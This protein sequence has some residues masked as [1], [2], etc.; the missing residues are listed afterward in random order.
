MKLSKLSEMRV[1]VVD[2]L[3]YGNRGKRLSTIDV[4]SVGP[5]LIAGI[6]EDLNIQYEFYL[7]KEA[8]KEI[9]NFRSYDVLLASG[10]ATDLGSMIRLAKSFK[11]GTKIAGGPSCVEYKKLLMSGYDFV[12]FGES[13][14]KLPL[15]IKDLITYGDVINNVEGLLRLKNGEVY[16]TLPTKYVVPEVLWKYK[17]SS[18]VIKKYDWWWGARTYIEVVRG[19]SNFYRPTLNLIRYPVCKNCGLCRE[20][21]LE[22]RIHCPLGIPPGCGY[23]SV[24]Q[25]YGPAR[26]KPIDKVIDEV[27]DL[28]RVGVRRIV[29][30]APDFLDYGRDWL[31]KPKPL[32]DPRNPKPNLKVIEE[33][34]TKLFDI[35]EIMSGDSYIMIENIKPNL[36]DEE[37]AKLLGNYLKGST[38]GIGL[39]TGDNVLHKALGRPSTVGEVVKAVKLLCRYGLKPH[40]YLIHGLPYEDRK[41]IKNTVN[42]VRKLSRLSIEKFTL[43]RFTPL[44]GT[45]FEGFQ[46]PP[47]AVESSQARELYEVVK[48]YNVALKKRAIGSIVKAVIASRKG[49]YLVAYPLPHGP[50]T[51]LKG[52]SCYIGNVVWVKLTKVASDRE[53]FG[54]VVKV[55]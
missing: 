12:V 45:A 37:V 10:M 31:I 38:L 19:C 18:S 29:L 32:T 1:A 2:C 13:E 14:D 25:I 35:S 49:P 17:P 27:K 44:K 26:S 8:I 4:I 54:D 21:D 48:K 51:L 53:M 42:I 15:I 9:E 20:A 39:E 5:R 40:I 47:A 23:C 3:G 36:V 52:P 22:S 43:Y 55:A 41:S 46:K 6:L 34:L 28:I 16:G 7:Y 50:V 33:L 24:P 30:S 11:G